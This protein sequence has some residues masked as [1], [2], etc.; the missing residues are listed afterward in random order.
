[1]VSR[2]VHLIYNGISD[3]R[4][5]GVYEWGMTDKWD[6]SIP[7]HKELAHGIEIG[8]GIPEMRPIALATQAIKNVGFNLTHDEDLADRSDAI[9]WYYP[10]EGDLSKA[11]TFW[12][13]ILC[14]RTSASGKFVTHNGLLFL[15]TLRIIPKGTKAV[16]DELKVAG[17]SVL[18]GGQTKVR[19][20]T[21]S[22]V[23]KY[24]LTIDPQ[25]F[26]PMYLAISTKPN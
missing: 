11:Q 17:D 23:Q 24:F 13:L 2:L 14:W 3:S 4:Q 20:P 21:T 7:E 1:M 9:P 12:D 16:C 18:A 22:Y 26:T 5:F 10:L 6:P 15:E 25:L 8:N 19:Y